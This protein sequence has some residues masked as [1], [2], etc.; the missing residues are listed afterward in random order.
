MLLDFVENSIVRKANLVYLLFY[1]EKQSIDS[2]ALKLNCASLTLIDDILYLQNEL[3]IAIEFVSETGNNMVILHNTG[4]SFHSILS[5]I[6]ST[7]YFLKFFE[8]FFKKDTGRYADYTNEHHLSTA[9]GYRLRRDIRTFIESLGLSL[10]ENTIT[11]R[12]IIIRFLA[13]ELQYNFNVSLFEL[14][15]KIANQCNSILNTIEYSLN[16]H[17]TKQER[18]LFSLLIQTSIDGL[19]IENG[20]GFSKAQLDSINSSIYPKQLVTLLNDNFSELWD[21][22]ENELNFAILSF[23][24]INSHLFD[25]TIPQDILKNNKNAFKNHPDIKRLIDSFNDTFVINE[26]LIDYFY[27]SLYLFIRDSSFDVQPITLGSYIQFSEPH[28]VTY[29]HL[30]RI[31]NEWNIYGVNLNKNHILNLYNRIAPILSLAL[32]KNIVIVSDKNIDAHFVSDYISLLIGNNTNIFID[33]NIDNHRSLFH[34]NHTVFI[35][36]KSSEINLPR[37]KIQNYI[38]TSFPISNSEVFYLLNT[39]SLI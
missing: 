14:D 5:K 29:R 37:N 32:Y 4:E 18:Y 1:S 28:T 33:N 3:E 11:G 27:T 24:V 21:D 38:F 7:S 19:Y 30:N 15:F 31:L 36:D 23:L 25:Q 34:D 20:F 12:G 26:Q 35:I 17:F 6:Y 9:T 13:A 2:L 16:I 22:P 10:D 8:Y 39:L